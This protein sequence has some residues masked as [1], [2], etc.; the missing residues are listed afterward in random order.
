MGSGLIGEP[1]G[2]P[3]MPMQGLMIV[4]LVSMVALLGASAGLA[5]HIWREHRKRKLRSFSLSRPEEADVETE[6]AP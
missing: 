2:S 4:F 1:S 6:E 5:H 3:M